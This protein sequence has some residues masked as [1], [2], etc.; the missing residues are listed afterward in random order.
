MSETL[1]LP[2][3]VI[4]FRIAVLICDTMEPRRIF[5]SR[6]QVLIALT[7]SVSIPSPRSSSIIFSSST[8]PA[9]SSVFWISARSAVD[10]PSSASFASSCIRS[11]LLSIPRLIARWRLPSAPSWR[12]EAETSVP[13]IAAK[14]VQSVLCF[15]MICRILSGA[16]RRPAMSSAICSNSGRLR[17]RVTW[18]A[19]KSSRTASFARWFTSCLRRR[20]VSS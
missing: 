2:A 19:L 16:T 9:L 3:C 18:P 7:M 12:A 11:L 14:S 6:R 15:T 13:Q 20:S 10:T 5:S 1:R 4:P 17:S 8:P